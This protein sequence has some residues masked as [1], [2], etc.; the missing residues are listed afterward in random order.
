MFV[1]SFRQTNTKVQRNLIAWLFRLHSQQCE[2]VLANLHRH[3][4]I[5]CDGIVNWNFFFII[6]VLKNHE[7]V[8]LFSSLKTTTIYI[9]I[10]TISV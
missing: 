5:N 8:K 2:T 3:K 9:Y 1:C 7:T 6:C 4:T 10:D